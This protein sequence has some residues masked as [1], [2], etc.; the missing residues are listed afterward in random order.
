MGPDLGTIG[1]PDKQHLALSAV[2]AAAI[3]LDQ[4]LCLEPAACLVLPCII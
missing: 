1:R 2:R 4:H 3:H